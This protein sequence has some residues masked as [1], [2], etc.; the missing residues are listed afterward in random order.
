MI[1]LPHRLFPHVLSVALSVLC[2]AAAWPARGQEASGPDMSDTPP[3]VEPTAPPP[4]RSAWTVALWYLPNRVMDLVDIFR[5]RLKVGPGLGATVRM[6]DYAAFFAGRQHTVFVGLPGPRYPD[7][8]RWPVGFENQRGIVLAGVDASDTLTHPPRYGFSEAGVGLHLGIVGA[9]AGVDPFEVADFLAG[10]FLMDLRS[11]D[12]PRRA[13]PDLPRR[14]GVVSHALVHPDYATD[15]KPERFDSWTSRLDYLETNVPLRLRGS[16][17]YV[18]ARFADES[19]PVLVQPPMDDL[20]FAIYVRSIVGAKTEVELK[21]DISL[22]VDLP[23]LERRISLFVESSGGDDLPGRDSIEREDRGWTVGARK[24]RDAWNIST[25]AGIRARW[26]PEVFARA[27]WR[28]DWMWDDWQFRFEQRV[29]WESE[30]GFGTLTSLAVHR[31]FAND[32]WLFKENTAGKISEVTDGYEWEQSV[33]VGRVFKLFDETRRAQ[34]RSI[35][36]TDAISGYSFKGSVFGSDD[37]VTQYRLLAGYRFDLY[38][39]FMIGELRA[40]PQW[41]DEEDWDAEL[42]TDLGVLFVF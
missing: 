29:F 15:P 5:L 6:T 17:H 28:P 4:Q 36:A 18:D 24:K 30:D 31:W 42:R 16:L 27:S 9:E 7:I 3:V 21:P 34:R 40:G 38:R 8:V 22:D 1:R 10:F 26:L 37:A 19:Q 14:G 41:R 25:D 33:S 20:S 32:K 23:N 35:G 2:F 11:D 13:A 12:Y 39:S